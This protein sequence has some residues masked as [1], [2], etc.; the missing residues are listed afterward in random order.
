MRWTN[1][2][3]IGFLIG[4]AI[5]IVPQI[6]FLQFAERFRK[7]GDQVDQSNHYA[8]AVV[9]GLVGAAVASAIAW[10]WGGSAEGRWTMHGLV[11]TLMMSSAVLGYCFWFR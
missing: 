7:P 2:D 4:S 3:T 6:A 8:I 11:A 5:F 9:L 1:S 10:K